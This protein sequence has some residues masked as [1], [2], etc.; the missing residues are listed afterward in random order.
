MPIN[1]L[2]NNEEEDFFERPEV[3]SILVTLIGVCFFALYL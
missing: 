3:K 1:F 2:D